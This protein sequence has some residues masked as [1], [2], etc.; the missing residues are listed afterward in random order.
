MSTG[1]KVLQ[2]PN[3]KNKRRKDSPLKESS[4]QGE[5]APEEE[6]VSISEK[7]QATIQDERRTVRRTILREFIGVHIVVPGRGLVRCALADI[8]EKGLAFD[9]IKPIGHL[10]SGEEVAMR[11]YMNHQTYFGFTVKI[12]GSRFLDDEGVYRHGVSFSEE[13]MNSNAIRHFAMFIESVSANLSRD[14]GDVMVSNLKG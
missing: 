12:K 3:P 7:R 13:T 2:F 14:G 4:A 5:I 6:V 9:L 11:I 8:S 1:G 10:K